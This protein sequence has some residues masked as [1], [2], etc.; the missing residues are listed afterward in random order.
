MSPAI[1]TGISAGL[2]ALIVVL[3]FGNLSG[4]VLGLLA[5]AGAAI[6]LDSRVEWPNRNAA[7]VGGVTTGAVAIPKP[8]FAL[9]EARSVSFAPIFAMWAP[10]TRSSGTPRR[11]TAPW[12]FW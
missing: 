5:G 10:P 9:P 2:L 4:V 6:L 11:C 8:N 12:T 7:I 1:R 3:L